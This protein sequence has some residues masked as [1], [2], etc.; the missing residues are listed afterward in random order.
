MPY[1]SKKM[2]PIRI[3]CV[4]DEPTIRTTM[5]LIFRAHGYE[6]TAVGTVAEA[7]AEIAAHPFDVLVADL[8]I[9]QQGDGFT[10]VSAMRR[11]HPDCV[12]IILTGF[13]AIEE[14]LRSISNQV[15]EVVVKPMNS[16]QMVAA[17]EQRLRERTPTGVIQTRRLSNILSEQKDEICKR[18]VAE[19]KRNPELA[20]LPLSDEERLDHTRL[21]L[22]ELV[23][24]LEAPVSLEV[25]PLPAAAKTGNERHLQEYPIALLAVNARLLQGV[26]Y[27][28]IHENLLSINLSYLMPD[29]KRLN[30][31]LSL[32]AE[33]IVR[34]FLQAEKRAA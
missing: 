25:S 21:T 7:L 31:I 18:I 4:D 15:D 3:L 10:V 6:A 17:I 16:P 9:G 2:S 32:Q 13:P 29:L 8:N 14:A 27:E 12:N 23:Q 30:E 20:T 5:P 34:K 26:I 33:E 22:T 28:L 11:T 19:M 1:L 24:E